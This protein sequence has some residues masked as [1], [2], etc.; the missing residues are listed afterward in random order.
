M[1]F[2]LVTTATDHEP[3]RLTYVDTGMF[4]GGA[5][6]AEGANPPAGIQYA[7]SPFLQEIKSCRYMIKRNVCLGYKRWLIIVFV[8]I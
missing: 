3:V 8:C 7:I 1:V 6:E 5:A 2:Q 4:S